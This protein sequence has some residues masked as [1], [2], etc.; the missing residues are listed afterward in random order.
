MKVVG[1]IVE[2]NP[3]HNGHLHHINEVRK[4]S[5]A[6]VLIAVMSSSVTMRG[7]LSI[8]DKFTKTRQALEASCDIVI[9]LPF[10]L[11]C[12]NSDL[13]A[14]H[15]IKMLANAKVDEIWIGS[16]SNDPKTFEKAYIEFN[17]P[18]VDDK[19]KAHL[20]RGLS[21]KMATNLIYPLQSNDLLG[22]S[23]Y[24]AIKAAN[25]NIKLLTI[26]R[27]GDDYLNK[28]PSNKG[29]ASAMSIR[30]NLD[31]LEKYTPEFVYKNKNL[32]LNDEQLFKFL[33]FQIVSKNEE[34]L[35]N[36]FF[37]EEG[38]ENKLKEITKYNDL[39]SFV[40]SL[41]SKRYTASRIRRFLMYVLFDITKNQMN[42]ILSHDLDFIRVLGFN[43]TGQSYLSN[44]KKELTIYTNIKDGNDPILDIEFRISKIL[45]AIYNLNLS[46]NEQTII[47]YTK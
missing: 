18:D 9:E 6:D 30:S 14:K 21:Y 12:Q 24:K 47:R 25:Y 3:F 5:G 40:N 2:Y 17:K 38:L 19:I 11:A 46:E 28:K 42:N 23:Y 33:K 10:V 45:D 8:F 32:I 4:K 22:Y 29:F 1:I 7:E 27:A 43:E 35:S 26:Q 44:I 16:E 15:T 31:L 36:L 13:F 34:Y 37:A 39:D 41:T 20:K